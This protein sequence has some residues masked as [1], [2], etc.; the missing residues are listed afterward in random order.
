MSSDTQDAVFAFLA[1][2]ATHSGR[3]VKRIDTHA[4]AVFLAGDAAYKVKRGVKFPFLDFSTL[5]KRKAALDAEIAANRAF[6]LEIYRAVIPIVRRNGALALGGDGNVIEWALEM[7]RF[8]EEKTLDCLADGARIDPPLIEALARAV[9]AAHAR[10]PITDPNT[11]I[12]ALGDYIEQ[13]DAALRER[14]DLFDPAAAAR[15]TA[16]SR[17]A[18]TRVRP[19][20]VAR[21]VEGLIRRGH[22]DLHLGNIAL[23]DGRPVP[24][25]ALEFDPIVASGDVFYDLAFLLMD[26]IERKLEGAANTVLNVYLAT[27]RRGSDL[28]ALAALPL[29]MSVRAAIRAKVTAARMANAAPDQRAPIAAQARTYFALAGGLIAPA[30]ARLVAVGGLSGTGKSKLARALAPSLAPSPGA[31]LLRSDVERKAMFNVAEADKLPP[32]AYAAEVAPRVYAVLAKKAHRVVAAGHSVIT[33]AVFAQPQERAEIA[34][35]A[36]GCNVAFAGLFLTADLATRIARVGNRV[37]DASDAD[38]DVARHQEGYALGAMDWI[39]IDAS[40]TRE[41][42]LKRAKAALNLG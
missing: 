1:D 33:D 26:L 27:T 39:A 29:F 23:I 24:F 25:D 28:D 22:G 7:H 5:D 3:A 36:R 4:A 17:A 15:L 31:V 6:A 14:A 41:E 10:A 30:A 37:H 9:A 12:A 21:G 8:D 32:Q 35:T 11:W 40:G 18:F 42:T 16:A 19:L 2:P 13:N 34:E 38:A 20:L